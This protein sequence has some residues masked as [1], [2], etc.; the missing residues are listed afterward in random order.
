MTCDWCDRS[1]SYAI[2]ERDGWRNLA[3]F[4][5]LMRW[6]RTYASGTRVEAV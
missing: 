1:A 5:C 4:R 6:L 3:C 2:V